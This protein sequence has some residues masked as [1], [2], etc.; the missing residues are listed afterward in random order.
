[1]SL[2][3]QDNAI[4]QNRQYF[5]IRIKIF[6]EIR[7][8]TPARKNARRDI[9]EQT[10]PAVFLGCAIDEK[11]TKTVRTFS[12]QQQ[13]NVNWNK[14]IGVCKKFWQNY[15]AGWFC[16]KILKFKK[17]GRDRNSAMAVMTVP[18]I[19][20]YKQCRCRNAVAY[21]NVPTVRRC[22]CAL[23]SG[24]TK[25]RTR[26]QTYKQPAEPIRC[27]SAEESFSL[28]KAKTAAYWFLL[29]LSSPIAK[30]CAQQDFRNKSDENYRAKRPSAFSN[31]RTVRFAQVHAPANNARHCSSNERKND[32]NPYRHRKR[33]KLSKALQCGR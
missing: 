19:P 6:A 16:V 12:R 26:P 10:Q 14:K 8:M 15:C 3:T 30:R 4:L 32:G 18:P 9:C 1:M 25:I 28:S 5:L 31:R 20:A 24:L 29:I 21:P 27:A 33:M 11:R 2:K 17:S 22:R 7:T 13:P 23:Y